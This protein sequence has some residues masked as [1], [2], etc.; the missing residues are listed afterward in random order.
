MS[1]HSLLYTFRGV[2][3]LGLLILISFGVI[4]FA[5]IIRLK[6]TSKPINIEEVKIN[7]TEKKIFDDCIQFIDNLMHV[8]IT[9]NYHYFLQAIHVKVT[10]TVQYLGPRFK[11][12]LILYLYKNGLIRTDKPFEQRL[13]LNGTNLYHLRFRNEILN[14]IYLP[15]V[16]L[17][18]SSFFNCQLKSSNF[19]RSFMDKSQ[20][21]NCLLENATFSGITYS[22][23]R[24]I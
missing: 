1:S 8:N 4:W 15:R 10:D 2:L 12:D 24:F 22:I 23:H 9:Q 19:Q 7:Q 20:F 5:S 17:L 18:N 6:P 11:R 14:N 16:I 3:V 21:I 13:H